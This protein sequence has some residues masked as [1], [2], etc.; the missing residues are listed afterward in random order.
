ME[1]V[2]ILAIPITIRPYH[3][4]KLNIFNVIIFPNLTIVRAFSFLQ[5]IEQHLVLVYNFCQAS[6]SIS[7]IE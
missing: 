6:D 5:F 4:L 1:E 7:S 2:R 3:L